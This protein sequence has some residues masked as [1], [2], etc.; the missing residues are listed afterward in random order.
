MIIVVLFNLVI[1]IRSYV[2]NR[3]DKHYLTYDLVHF[4]LPLAA[5]KGVSPREQPI[6][7]IIEKRILTIRVLLRD[8]S[9]FSMKFDI[10]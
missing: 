1:H 7:I 3:C 10:K 5:S 6:K 2:N 8:I 4:C 9:N